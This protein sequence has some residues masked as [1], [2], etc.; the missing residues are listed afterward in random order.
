MS[1]RSQQSQ[2]QDSTIEDQRFAE[3]LK[4]IKDLTQ[5]WEVPLA[6]IM[7]EYMDVLQQVTITFDGGQTSVN[8]AQAALVLQGTASVYSKKVDFLW[9]MVL[10]TTELLRNKE[11]NEGSADGEDGGGGGPGKGRKKMVD[12]TREFELLTVDIAKN[13]DIKTDDEETVN[14]RKNALNFI[15]VTPRQLIEKEG[16]EQKSVKVNLFMGVANAKWD[17][18][19]AKE[20]FRING[21]YV[22]QTGYLGEELNVDNQYLNLVTEETLDGDP[23]HVSIIPDNEQDNDPDVNDDPPLLNDNSVAA[24][25]DEIDNREGDVSVMSERAD[26]Q[27]MSHVERDVLASPPPPPEPKIP[28][29]PAFDPWE[30]LD[31]HVQMSTPKPIKVKKT[32]RI[33][34]SLKKKDKD[35]LNEDLIP[36]SQ[37]INQEMLQDT[38]H[39]KM[40]PEVPLCF[41]DLMKTEYER[42]KERAR[43]ERVEER[44]RSQPRQAFY[45]PD[46]DQDDLFGDEGHEYED[47]QEEGVDHVPDDLID[48][49]DLPNPHMGGDIGAVAAGELDDH[50]FNADG[51]N[52]DETLSYEEMVAKKVEQFVTKSQEYMRSSELAMKVAKWHEMIGPRLENVERRNA[53][54]IHAYGSMILNNFTP[55]RSNVSFNS[56]VRGQKPEEKSRY[57]LSMLM[58]ANTENVEISTADGSDPQ[59]GMDNVMIK[60]LSTSRHHQQLEEFQAAS[61]QGVADASDNQENVLVNVSAARERRSSGSPPMKK[62]SK[63]RK[64]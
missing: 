20:D 34:P 37:Y 7:S 44:K 53:F 63:K 4:P 38:R 49:L 3:L 58:L 12:M 13:I 61:S 64:K 6:E 31:P 35:R 51:D 57:F 15:Y 9:Q 60:L 21:Q 45:E 27:N 10:K 54:D 26:G 22:S 28:E 43:L 39:H 23:N 59:L 55:Q 41:S 40:F 2:S 50:D 14:E 18:L 8:F 30:P 46:E 47:L 42:R 62:P 11:E 32:L 52:S 16:S 17:L 33:P 1:S 36:I 29:T 56:V 25:F 48:D 5:N 24:P 19:A